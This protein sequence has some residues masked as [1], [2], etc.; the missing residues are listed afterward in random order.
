MS[1]HGLDD[2]LRDVDPDTWLA[3]I[4]TAL[5]Q[6][7]GF[8]DWLGCV[9]EIG[10]ADELRVV[11]RL[12][13]F[14]ATPPRGLRLQTRVPRQAPVL[15][16][17]IGLLPGAAWHQREVHDFF[18]VVF[19]GADLAPL[20]NHAPAGAEPVRG[21]RKDV[22]LAARAAQPWPGAK[23]PGEGAAAPSR[24]KMAPPGVP[25]PDVWGDRDPAAPLPDPAEIAAAVAGGRVR[26][27]R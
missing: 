19:D 2:Q 26:R 8:F 12:V 17:C 20:L 1:A 3:A 16:S 7:F 23:E 4:S 27:R 15:P 11:L 22:V 18:G 9:D 13:N 10:R 21:L 6:G 5:A 25:D 14:D 24:R